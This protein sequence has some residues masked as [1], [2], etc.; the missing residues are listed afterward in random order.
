MAMIHEE[1]VH[2]R[3]LTLLEKTMDGD[4]GFKIGVSQ[5][6]SSGQQM[7]PSLPYDVIVSQLMFK[8]NL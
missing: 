4:S 2:F 7:E 3:Y 5:N 1:E 6:P 8:R